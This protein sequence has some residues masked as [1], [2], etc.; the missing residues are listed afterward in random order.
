MSRP[1]ESPLLWIELFIGHSFCDGVASQLSSCPRTPH[2]T[3]VNCA[4]CVSKNGEEWR[5]IEQNNMEE[6]GWGQ[7]NLQIHVEGAGRLLGGQIA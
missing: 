3:I 5:G 1:I 2:N 6:E 4:L 7:C